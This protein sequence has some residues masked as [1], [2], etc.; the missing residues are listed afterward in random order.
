MEP[1]AE[2]RHLVAAGGEELGKV[3]R[4]SLNRHWPQDTGERSRV[5]RPLAA[6]DWFLA[7]YSGPRSLALSVRAGINDRPEER[8]GRP[9]SR[10]V[11]TPASFRSL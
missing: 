9:V 4:R 7:H 10:P 11:A 2:V 8:R 1:A 6:S 3:D 5:L